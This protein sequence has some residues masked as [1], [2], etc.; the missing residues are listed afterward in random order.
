MFEREQN[1]FELV[2]DIFYKFAQTT[3]ENI[4][5]KFSRKTLYPIIEFLPELQVVI[6]LPKKQEESYVF[7]GMVFN[8]TENGRKSLWSLFLATLYHMAAH[9]AI[10]DYKIY[11]K[12]RKNK[13]EEFCHKVIDFI[14][15]V[16]VEKYISHTNPEIW[17]NL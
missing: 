1:F 14:E 8:D 3:P 11:D 5:F 16:S 6:P 9:A 7:E 2:Y 15:D 13:T 12:W 4:G 17:S 10:S